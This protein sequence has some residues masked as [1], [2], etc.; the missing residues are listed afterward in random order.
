LRGGRLARRGNL[1]EPRAWLTTTRTGLPR[2]P[3][4]GPPRNDNEKKR[5]AWIATPRRARND[6]KG[7]RRTH[8]SLP[9]KPLSFLVLPSP[10]HPHPVIARSASDAAIQPNHGHGTRRPR[11]DCHVGLCESLLAMTTRKSVRHGLRRTVGLAMTIKVE[12]NPLTLSTGTPVFPR[13]A[14]PPAPP[15]PVIA[16]SPSD[17]AIQPNHGHGTRRPGLDCR[18]G[19]CESL[20]AMTTRKGERHGL[21]RHVGLAMTSRTSERHG[22]PRPVGLAMTARKARRHGVPRLKDSQGQNKSIVFLRKAP[23]FYL[24]Y[25]L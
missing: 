3:L 5:K 9:P 24:V 21:P 17:A 8:F 10:P 2:R 15:H 13:F 20:L 7:S 1:A 25:L 18:V 23:K 19:L 6:N 11:L 4:R 12:K 16:R 22:L 14:F